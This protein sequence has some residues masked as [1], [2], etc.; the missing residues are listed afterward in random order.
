MLSDCTVDYAKAVIDPFS[1]SGS[2]PCIPDLTILPSNKIQVKI[3]GTLQ[4]GLQGTGYVLLNPF[5]A[6]ANNNGISTVYINYPIIYTD[7]NYDNGSIAYSASGGAFLTAGIFGANGNSPYAG[8][9]ALQYRVVAAGLKV[10]YTGNE[11]Y[12]QGT[13]HTFRHPVNIASGTTTANIM[14]FNYSRR[15]PVARSEEYVF[16]TP[17]STFYTDYHS[18]AE[19][20][21]GLTQDNLFQLGIWITGGAVGNP[22]P[23]IFEAVV[24]FE[25]Q[26][27]GLPLSPSHSDTVGYGGVLSAL[28]TTAPMGTPKSI[29]NSVLEGAAQAV[30]ENMSHVVQSIGPM[31]TNVA[32]NAGAAMA[33]RA[34]QGAARLL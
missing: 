6:Y 8:N 23:W 10:Q 20:L 11:L 7:S 21:P 9:N 15:Q 19:L 24:F 18:D 27:T 3:R 2:L 5:S 13:V 33:N 25:L 34:I 30:R 17:S 1:Y 14:G 32:T 22:Q 4:T 29:I 31:V 16:Y 28:P 12:K 26:G